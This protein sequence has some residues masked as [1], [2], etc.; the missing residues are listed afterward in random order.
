MTG[1]H[2]QH[3]S[4]NDSFSTVSTADSSWKDFWR[5][6]TPNQLCMIC[7]VPFL[8]IFAGCVLLGLVWSGRV[9]PFRQVVLTCG[10][11]SFFSGFLTCVIANFCDA[12]GVTC[13]RYDD[14]PTD[15]EVQSQTLFFDL[16]DLGPNLIAYEEN[17][18]N[19]RSEFQTTITEIEANISGGK[20]CYDELLQMSPESLCL[21][22]KV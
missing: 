14:G 2:A 10:M 15:C 22:S 13:K 20:D 17:E 4:A 12:C 11:V 3:V 1:Q 6:K 8:L 16:G 21:T 5:W 7:L 9:D 19:N 18:A